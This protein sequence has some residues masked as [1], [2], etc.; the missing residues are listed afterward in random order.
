MSEYSTRTF[1]NRV[2]IANTIS[3]H[4]GAAQDLTDLASGL[5]T[6]ANYTP[7]NNGQYW[8]FRRF[9]HD[10]FCM[11]LIDS[12]HFT[13]YELKLADLGIL[14]NSKRLNQQK[15]DLFT[16][17]NNQVHVCELT[18]TYSPEIAQI[19]KAEKYKD[20]MKTLTQNGFESTFSVLTVDL[21]N[22]EWPLSFPS[23][24]DLFMQ[25]IQDMLDALRIIHTAPKFNALRK[26]ETG[27]YSVDRFQFKTED[28]TIEEL[29]R[30]A[31]GTRVD[32]SFSKLM[33]EGSDPND[34]E[35]YI[36]AISNSILNN[37]FHQR[38]KPKPEG[39]EPTI[40]IKDFEKMKSVQPTTK[41]I[42]RVLQLGAPSQVV[43]SPM[44][45]PEFISSI[46]TTN[47]SGGYLDYIKSSLDQTPVPD[48]HIIELP[49]SKS[50]VEKEQSEGPGRKTYL[51]K[52]GLKQERSAPTHLGYSESHCKLV[53][54]L[55]E[56]IDSKLI[57]RDI[58]ELPTQ[59]IEETGLTAYTVLTD[60]ESFMRGTSASSL[61]LFYQKISNEIV[62][63]SMRRRKNREYALGYSGIK[64]IFFIIASGPQLRTESSVEFVKIIS[65]IPP[66][67][68]GLS[69]PWRETGDHWESGWLSVD[70]DRLKQWQ[71]AH[72]R[73]F[74]SLVTSAERL[75]RPGL[76][77]LKAVKEEVKSGNYMLMALVYL[78]NKQT[79]STTNQTVRYL[80]M[81]SIGDKQFENL[82]S[83]FPQRVNSVLQ[84]FILQKSVETCV[85]LC[86]ENLS[87]L[88]NVSKTVRDEETGH[89]DESTT[90][91][92]NL[93]P[94]LF[95]YGSNVPISYNLNEIY[96]CMSYN[97][98]RQNTTQDAMG[99]LEKILKEETKYENEIASRKG[100]DKV[101]YFF[102]STT[103]SADINH[104]HTDKPESHYYSSRAVHCGI[105]LQDKHSE[106]AGDNGSWLNS[107]KL[108]KIL[109]RNLSEFA[110][111]KASVKEICES[112][113]VGDLEEVKK[114]GRRTKAIELVAEIV[115]D[116]NLMTA[117][118]VAMSYSGP[119]N[120]L[121]EVLIQI[122]KKN[123]I[124]GTRE[125]IILFIKARIIFNIVEEVARLLSKS[126]KREILTKGR[127]KR[128]MMRGDYEAVMSSFP[129]GTPLRV[130][131][132]SY[133]MTTWAQKFIPT[134]FIPLFEHHF[135]SFP[136][137]K[138]LSRFIFLS[139][140]NK[141]MEYPKKL[142]EQWIRNPSK[143]HDTD[144][145]QNAKRRFFETGNPW[146]YNHSNMCQGIP[147]YNSTVLAL[148][149]LSL[150]DALFESCLKQLGTEKS[151]SYKTRVG[152]DDKGTILA[153]DLTKKDS[154]YQYL[155][156]GQCERA[157][158]RLH[159]MELSVK[160]ASGHLMYELNSAF[161]ANL[162]T[163]S[164]TIKFSFAA[165]DTI[166]TVSCTNFINESYGR[167]RQLRENGASSIICS[168]AHSLNSRHFY[169][170]F[171]TDRGGEN[172]LT[173]IFKTQRVKIPYD[174]G[175]Y[176]TYDVD[177]QDVIGPEFYN[178]RIVKSNPESIPVKMLYTELSNKDM[179]EIFPSDDTPLLKKDH[180]GINQGLVRQLANMR[181]R[182]SADP[183]SIESYFRSNPFMIV[184]G[185]E[186]QLETLNTILA[187]L[188]TKGASEA[189]R[190]TSAAIYI[191]RLSAF[192]SAKAWTSPFQNQEC[193]DL[194]TNRIEHRELYTKATYKEF[195]TNSI[196]KTKRINTDVG[197]LLTVL[198]PQHQSFEIVS[199]MCG[200]FGAMRSTDKKFSQA[201]R[202]WTVNNFNYEYTS[203]LKS[204]LETSFG[205]SHESS[206]EDVEEFR[207][208]VKMKLEN[209]P[210]FVEE[211]MGKKLR[212]LDMFFY[213]TKLHKSSRTSRIQ[214]FGNGPSTS[215]L[216]TT[217]LSLKKYNHIPGMISELDAGIDEFQIEIENS[218]SQK[219]DRVKFYHNLIVMQKNGM[220]D[221][222]NDRVD[223][224]IKDVKLSEDCRTTIRSIKT[225]SGLDNTTQKTLKL[226]ACELLEGNE[227]KEKLVKWRSLNY[228]YIRKQKRSVTSS[229]NVQWSGDLCVLVSADTECY[230]INEKRGRRYIE[231]KEITDL[232]SLFRSL[233]DMCR[234]L[235]MDLPSFFQ[236]RQMN[237]G[238]IYLSSTTKMLNRSE[239]TTSGSVLNYRV[240]NKFFYRRLTDLESFNVRTTRNERTNEIQMYLED[241]LGRTA[242][243]CHSNG[244]YYPVEVPQGL[245]I[246]HSIMYLG[247]K[248]GKLLQN[249]S[250]FHNFW[251]P[252]MTEKERID[253]LRNDVD[254]KTVLRLES[255][256]AQ[257]IQDYVEVRDEVNE[258][259]FSLMRDYTESYN[260][261]MEIGL[262]EDGVDFNEMFRST[263]E[264]IEM[265]AEL[266]TFEGGIDS[267]ADEVEE[268][269]DEEIKNIEESLDQDETLQMV[270]AF[271]YKRPM[272]RRA[273]GTIS[274][275]QQG[276]ALK[277]RIM[278]CLFTGQDIR[279]EKQSHLAHMYV[280][281]VKTDFG[282]YNDLAT[283]V[284]L[285]IARTIATSIGLTMTKVKSTF[286]N[287]LNQY[288]I[289]ISVL[290]SLA[291]HVET[292]KIDMMDQLMHEVGQE[293]DY[294]SDSASSELN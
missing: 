181:A 241:K 266:K 180:F 100:L 13:G 170:V 1:R 113:D 206:T 102:G 4:I 7:E 234:T 120:K 258:E 52:K 134:I 166:G 159:S 64:G 19:E 270:K 251:L 199:T 84:S 163:L 264:K 207:R 255:R 131:K 27:S 183:E 195:I 150:R 216:H 93:M 220:L 45:Y 117:S 145:M 164:P 168:F 257:R 37:K 272:A 196:E 24:S 246:D 236:R 16:L 72:D 97:K 67:T 218:L 223:A 203:S 210:Q 294:D 31:T 267:W 184:R 110:T 137:V 111:F 133:D 57:I 212:P 238:D 34:D 161:M 54:R 95:T 42:K 222:I 73:V 48:S 114:L 98:D 217:A 200:Q 152:S 273:M 224:Q 247:V 51:K 88:V 191:G 80:W 5:I 283:E 71:R 279:K 12:A 186:T 46:R 215:G 275:L 226:L 94:R 17:E 91:V 85:R 189:L 139:H 282:E 230:T 36:D 260:I 136:G 262:E 204:I 256:D 60:I 233:R 201:V 176:P 228:S 244:N 32:P 29:V 174:F 169:N 127:D 132:E 22:P 87:S 293:S 235:G 221:G 190:R 289:P 198:F 280:W 214:A 30:K 119:S 129:K 178:Y 92:T 49:L 101:K 81:K 149:C 90:G 278:D 231:T 56:D 59:D 237:V 128:L 44:T 144:G 41:K 285:Y 130:V 187:K 194:E 125:I 82:M 28:S 61:L 173:S 156:L 112:I 43:E 68:T 157:S 185:P 160:S 15:P 254:M 86:R 11:S 146:F 249:R 79:T 155:L 65:L 263:I 158:E 23:I 287:N 193:F 211:C 248:L 63:N 250:W 188:F 50:Q 115:K 122:F 126:D 277:R 2:T 239:S 83:K 177:L 179:D 70:V 243:I 105:R 26:E 118:E 167:I 89:Y 96:W 141:R 121:F 75:V 21:S 78:E 74:L 39:F 281:C 172:D 192:R 76:S 288:Q 154:Y 252:S 14:V 225:L 259:S 290:H 108:D 227:L 8:Q 147:H 55:I 219:L 99:I 202:T 165:V 38:T 284:S 229:G 213:M 268:F 116:E 20:F 3:T 291:F 142:V 197:S 208:L 253:F 143:E 103:T 182:L 153:M 6:P 175:I 274:A 135:K 261:Q 138:D 292:S 66:I 58:H 271:G 25:I 47:K 245:Q 9:L 269:N 148:S 240:T 123:Q 10:I 53:D 33:M 151:I 109:S 106:N 140:S 242:T 124:G 232:G 171:D 77:L 107:V 209:L 18:V 162:E 62:L 286:D 276:G 35:R 104:I 265:P 69:E 40:M 205:V